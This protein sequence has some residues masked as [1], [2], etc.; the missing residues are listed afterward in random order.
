M[1]G[2]LMLVGRIALCSI[3]I[4][5]AASNAS[6]FKDLTAVMEA[7]Q[8]PMPTVLLIAAIAFLIVGSLSVIVGFFARI[9]AL[10]L[11]AFLCAATYYFHNFWDMSEPQR[12]AE[13]FNFLRN[14]SFAGAMLMI[15]AHGAG[16]MSI[17]GRRAAKKA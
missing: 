2:I 7:K 8:M 10:M 12:Q 5:G 11:L 15:I 6:K 17:D 1:R 13:M 9:G 3:F 16:P 14:V 4:V